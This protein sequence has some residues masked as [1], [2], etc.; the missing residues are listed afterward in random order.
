VCL[1]CKSGEASW[2]ALMRVCK[3]IAEDK[4]EKI[5]RPSDWRCPE[6]KGIAN[7]VPQR[8]RTRECRSNNLSP[9]APTPFR[10]RPFL[11]VE[12]RARSCAAERLRPSC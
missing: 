5:D 4:E 10:L 1:A 7:V 9:P 11:T 2:Y 6:A 8:S 12:S 3:Q